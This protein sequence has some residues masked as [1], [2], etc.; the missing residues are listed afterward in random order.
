MIVTGSELKIYIAT[1][2]V[3]LRCGHDGLAAKVQV[4]LGL[5][6][7]SGAAFVFQSKRTDRI[8]ILVWNRTGLV[9]VHILKGCKFVW[10]RIRESAMSMDVGPSGGH[11]TGMVKIGERLH[12]VKTDSI[13]RIMLADEIDPNRT[14]I[15]VPNSQQE[16]LDCG[17]D[18]PLVAKTLLTGKQL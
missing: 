6:P 1:R 14:N 10:P 2:P 13:S 8:K 3:D 15:N 5:D 17:S 7:L 16:V 12:T 9:L 11:I 4:T 18:S